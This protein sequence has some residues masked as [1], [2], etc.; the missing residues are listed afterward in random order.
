MREIRTSGLM[1]GDGKRDGASIAT[2]ALALDSTGP[3]LVASLTR[4]RKS[5]GAGTG[6]EKSLEAARTSACATLRY[7]ALPARQG[8]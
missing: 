4:W 7:N 8:E 3:T 2:P 5:D 1:S 6:V